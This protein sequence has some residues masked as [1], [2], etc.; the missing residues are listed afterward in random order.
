MRG[1]ELGKEGVKETKEQSGRC[2][3]WP[4]NG[5]GSESTHIHTGPKCADNNREKVVCTITGG[6]VECSLFLRSSSEPCLKLL[7]LN[8]IHVAEKP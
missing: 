2:V 6:D 4:K 7:R 1:R 3:S 5:K 8:S